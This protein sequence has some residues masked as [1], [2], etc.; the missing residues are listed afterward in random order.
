M[1]PVLLAYRFARSAMVKAQNSEFNE[2]GIQFYRYRVLGGEIS[3]EVEGG[4]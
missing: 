4:K 1:Q 3:V 2:R